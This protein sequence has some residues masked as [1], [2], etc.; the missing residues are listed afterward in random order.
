[1]RLRTNM[2][3]HFIAAIRMWS[4][5]YTKPTFSPHRAPAGCARR[6]DLSRSLHLLRVSHIARH[7]N[8]GRQ[9]GPRVT[10]TV[11]LIL[12]ATTDR[13]QHTHGGENLNGVEAR[14]GG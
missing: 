13:R 3:G 14:Y 8:G 5:L 7:R 12:A 1:M 11:T 4:A 2:P 6:R 10:L 9:E